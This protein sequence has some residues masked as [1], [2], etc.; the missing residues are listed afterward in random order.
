MN[1]IKV[2]S[3]PSVKNYYSL[4]AKFEEF[5]NMKI[6]VAKVSLGNHYKN[7]VIAAQVLGAGAKR[8]SV[9]IKVMRRGNDVYFVRTDM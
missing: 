8:W 5:L 3:V 7:S 2:E 1:F 6:K 4:E 9:P